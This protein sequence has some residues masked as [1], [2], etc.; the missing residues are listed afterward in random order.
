MGIM[1]RFI[2][3]VLHLDQYLGTLLTQYGS[4]TY[5]ILFLI[6]FIETGLVLTPFLPGDSLL[7]AAGAFAGQGLLNVFLLIV[8]LTTAAVLGD[9]VNYW[10]G[11]HFGERV[12][13]KSRFYHPEY[14]ERTNHFF[15]KYGKKTIFLARF[16]PVVRTFAPFAAGIGKM[17]YPIFLSYNVLGGIVWVTF[18]ILIGYFFG[19]IPFVQQNFSWFIVGIILLSFVPL[20]RE[21]WKHRRT[22]VPEK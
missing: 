4:L 21:W 19:T 17:S 1:G 13:Q 2:D 18:F 10:L 9:T 12:F 3:I 6:I 7:F 8:M 11:Y 20:V 16:V 15:E 5:L 22:A 14:L